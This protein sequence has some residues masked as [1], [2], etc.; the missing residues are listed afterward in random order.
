[1][2]ISLVMASQMSTSSMLTSSRKSTCSE[3]R[4]ATFSVASREKSSFD[5]YAPSKSN[6]VTDSHWPRAKKS[7]DKRAHKGTYC[8]TCSRQHPCP[9]SRYSLQLCPKRICADQRSDTTGFVINIIQSRPVGAHAFAF[10][11]FKMH[12]KNK[13]VNRGADTKNQP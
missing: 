11:S 12:H 3:T 13:L 6:P 7:I 2:P 4:A 8:A 9:Q 1:M 10:L 5:S